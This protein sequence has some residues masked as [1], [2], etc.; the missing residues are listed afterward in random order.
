MNLNRF[1]YY[2]SIVSI[3]VI[4][5]GLGTLYG[6]REKENTK[7]DKI[8]IT[9]PNLSIRNSLTEME[10]RQIEGSVDSKSITGFGQLYFKIN[11]DRDTTEL[12]VNL[13]S[14]PQS[15]SQ[16]N[17]TNKI[18]IPNTLKI[19]TAK[20]SV[21]GLNY[22]Y[23]YIGSITLE[24]PNN[25]LRSGRFSTIIENKLSSLERIVLFADD[26]NIQNVFVDTSP[27]LPSEVR[28]KPAPFFWIDL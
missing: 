3:V 6:M 7:Q 4:A 23:E 10:I 13:T 17:Q 20:R 11:N 15:I 27:D 9:G 2:L 18:D 14:V 24:E 1:W 8:T 26:E 21:D 22:E 5:F 25:N 19:S 28:K 12:L 16:S